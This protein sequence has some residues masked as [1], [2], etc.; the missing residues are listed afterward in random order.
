MKAPQSIT[1][2]WGSLTRVHAREQN[3]ES[4]A[5]ISEWLNCVEAYLRAGGDP[6]AEG[7]L[8]NYTATNARGLTTT[9]YDGVPM[10]FVSG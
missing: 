2:E 7:L 1:G 6:S 8:V 9:E 3:L 4:I 10:A 5:V